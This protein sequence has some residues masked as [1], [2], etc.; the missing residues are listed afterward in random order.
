MTLSFFRRTSSLKTRPGHR[1]GFTLVELLVVIAIIGILVG[2]L[3]PAVQYARESA[4]RMQCSNNLKQVSLA[5]HNYSS[6]HGKFPITTTGSQLNGSVCGNGFYSWMAILL[7]YIE[8]QNLYNSIDFSIGMMD[9]CG[10][11]SDSAYRD[12]TISSSHRNAKAAQTIVPTYLC[13]SDP[14]SIT[15]ALGTSRPAP[16]SYAGNLGWIRFAT[17]IQ[18]NDGPL[19]KHNGAMPVINPRG[20]DPWQQGSLSERDFID[21]LSNTA[22]IAERRINSGVA[23][24]GPFGAQLVGKFDDSVLS[25]CASSGTARSLPN[26]IVYCDNASPLD[27]TYAVPHGKSWISGW[28]L[29]SNLYAHVMPINKKNCHIY[30][31]EDDGTNV[32][33]ASSQHVG[34]AMVAFGDGH[35]QFVQANMANEV[36]WGIGS[37]NGQEVVSLDP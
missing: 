5:I 1:I 37:R 31:G 14:F 33:T 3:L 25:F 29:A 32:V 24:S 17:G 35:I 13:P 9:Q 28:T 27:P 19:L 16:G 23:V 6:T 2:L 4:R 34:G 15:T 10:Q 22:L 30:G 21:G 36:W 11:V 8:Q 20:V 18:G 7:P 26:W 12:L